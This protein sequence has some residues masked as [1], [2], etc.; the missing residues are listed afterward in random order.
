M[1]TSAARRLAGPALGVL[2]FVAALGI[3]ELWAGAED[4]FL[5]PTASEVAERAWDVWPT[6]DFLSEVGQSMKRLRRRVRHRGGDRHRP[7]A[8]GRGVPRRQAH[9]RSV[10][11][12]PA[13]RAGDRDRAGGDRHPRARRRVAHRG[14]RLRPVLSDPRQHGRRCARHS[15]GGAGHRLDAARRSGGARSRGSTF[16]A[17]LPSI[18]AGLRIA[19]SLGLVLVVVSEFVGEANGLGYYLIVQQSVFDVS[20]AVRGHPLPR[21]ARLRAQPALPRRRAPRARLALRSSR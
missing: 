14:H 10:P 12:V 15:A 2:V 8:P 3:W 5:V 7:R 13:S 16:P 6:S 21:P 11:R 18:M 17:A 20:R 9:A 1:K 4:S 19:V